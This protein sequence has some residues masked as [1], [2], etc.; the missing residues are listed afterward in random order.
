[1]FHSGLTVP[2]YCHRLAWLCGREK[3]ADAREEPTD[4]EKR[5]EHEPCITT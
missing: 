1:M 4:F 2:G 3:A 5:K